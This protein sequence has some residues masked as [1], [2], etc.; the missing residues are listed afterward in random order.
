ME[1]L[2]R[3]LSIQSPGCSSKDARFN[4]QDSYGS[5]HPCIAPV[6]GAPTPS[7]GPL[8]VPSTYMVHRHAYKQY[9]HALHIKQ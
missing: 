2:E 8:K 6:L 5:L 3:Q 1:E 4:F 7:S 9:N